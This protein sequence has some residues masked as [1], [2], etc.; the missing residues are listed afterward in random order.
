MF[1]LVICFVIT[2]LYQLSE[3]VGELY[4][5]NHSWVLWYYGLRI[6][7]SLELLDDILSDGLQTLRHLGQRVGFVYQWNMD[8]QTP[9]LG[10]VERLVVDKVTE[11]PPGILRQG[12]LQSQ[13]PALLRHLLTELQEVQ[14][15]G[16]LGLAG[17]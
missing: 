11:I 2:D 1:K 16:E 3:L 9:A 8:E 7:S 15:A 14:T 17:G 13:P 4:N 12:G 5:R 6:R 10:G